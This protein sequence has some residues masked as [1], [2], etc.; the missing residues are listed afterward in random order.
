ML[1]EKFSQ[2]SRIAGMV[3]EQVTQTQ[4][5]Q[6][7]QLQNPS[8]SSSKSII[9][10][11][12]LPEREDAEQNL[13]IVE[14]SNPI[15]PTSPLNEVVPENKPSS[16]SY[17]LVSGFGSFQYEGVRV[18]RTFQ[19]FMQVFGTRRGINFYAVEVFLRHVNDF[20]DQVRLH[21]YCPTD[22]IRF[23]NHC[24]NLK[25]IDL[26]E[27][28]VDLEAKF[29]GIAGI[30]SKLK[31]YRERNMRRVISRTELLH[32]ISL[33]NLCEII[34]YR[35]KHVNENQRN[36]KKVSMA[37]SVGCAVQ[38]K[39]ND[40]GSK[41]SKESTNDYDQICIATKDRTKIK[42]REKR[43]RKR[44]ANNLISDENVTVSP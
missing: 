37:L 15:S 21:R 19:D 34:F 16:L 43:Q 14:V 5:F 30:P 23:E 44:A 6:T 42:Q 26:R 1:H 35:P 31:H 12:T 22:G 9:V 28:S 39:S 24:F 11:S 2:D 13:G 38:E 41:R 10:R 20:S 7:T 4:S 25:I 3:E 32:A 18:F 40:Q 8:R 36:G 17:Q 29:Y 33:P 27:P